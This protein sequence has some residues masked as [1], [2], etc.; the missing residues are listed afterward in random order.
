MEQP[1]IR[2]PRNPLAQPGDGKKQVITSESELRIEEDNT[3]RALLDEILRENRLTNLILMEA[4]RSEFGG[5]KIEDL[6][7]EV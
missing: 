7:R 2:E 6:R 4:F 3:V 1:E 5:L